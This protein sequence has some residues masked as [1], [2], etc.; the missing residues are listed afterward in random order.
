MGFFKKI[1]GLLTSHGVSCIKS[2]FVNLAKLEFQVESCIWTSSSSHP[3]SD[4]A[5]L[6]P[7]PLRPYP[8]YLHPPLHP[9]PA[10]FPSPL[11]PRSNFHCFPLDYVQHFYPGDVIVILQ[12]HLGLPADKLLQCGIH[13]TIIELGVLAQRNQFLA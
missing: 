11:R 4:P 2:H 13:F 5:A 8:I 6:F 1:I 7:H 9:N 10:V 12:Y 3:L